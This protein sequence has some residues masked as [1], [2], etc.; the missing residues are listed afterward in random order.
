M[1]EIKS[2]ACSNLTRLELALGNKKYLTDEQYATLLTENG[3]EPNLT[4]NATPENKYRLLTT[5]LDVLNTLANNIDMFRK[6][7]TEFSNTTDASKA[8]FERIH[9]LE[10][11]I[12]SSAMYEAPVSQISYL[13]FN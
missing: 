9:K 11:E 1:S 2:Y 13:Y 12:A 5:E 7:E 10:K 8:L 3:L 4:Y 6:V